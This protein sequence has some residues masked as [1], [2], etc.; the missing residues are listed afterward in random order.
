MVTS[1]TTLNALPIAPQIGLQS[2]DRTHAN[3]NKS[4][5][6]L[7]QL[8]PLTFPCKDAQGRIIQIWKLRQND[9]IRGV[10]DAHAALTV[11][12]GVVSEEY[13]ALEVGVCDFGG[14][15]VSVLC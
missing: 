6:I 2:S 7:K 3:L 12:S 10:L 11:V 8:K 9:L 5:P 15:G 13:T 4:N 1:P 14:H